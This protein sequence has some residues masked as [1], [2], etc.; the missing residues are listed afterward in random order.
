VQ[1]HVPRVPVIRKVRKRD[2][3][4][5]IVYTIRLKSTKK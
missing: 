2:I 4:E 5:T 3:W 1:S